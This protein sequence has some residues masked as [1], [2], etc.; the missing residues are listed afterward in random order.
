MDALGGAR[1]FLPKAQSQDRRSED[2]LVHRDLVTLESDCCLVTGVTSAKLLDLKL[3]SS[4]LKHYDLD[5]RL[6]AWET[7]C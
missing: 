7:R 5:N 6:W 1:V 3:A 2:M 4:E